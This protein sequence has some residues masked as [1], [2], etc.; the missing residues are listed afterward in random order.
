MTIA[1]AVI[2]SLVI[3]YCLLGAAYFWLK[4]GSERLDLI[5]HDEH[6]DTEPAAVRSAFAALNPAYRFRRYSDDER[7]VTRV[8]APSASALAD[9]SR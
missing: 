7:L 4:S 5:A 6:R 1:I 3:L 8:S 9:E 2:A